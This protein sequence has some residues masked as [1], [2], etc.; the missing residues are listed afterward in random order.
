MKAIQVKQFGEPKVM[1]IAEVA[2]LE[3]AADQLLIEVKAIGVNPVDTY[4]R[5]GTYPIKPNLPYTPGHDAAGVVLKVGANVSKFKP[6]DRV[7]THRNVSGSY[8][9]QVLCTA[10]QAGR[11]PDNVDFPAGAALGV[12]YSTAF[13]GLMHRGRAKAGETVLIHG[14]SGAVGIAAIQ[15]AKQL[16]MM[17]I[18]TAGTPEG[19]DLIRQ[20]GVSTALNHHDSDYLQKIQEATQGQGVDLILEMLA[21]VNLANDLQL[22]ARNGRV[23][24]IGNRGSIEINPRDTMGK[25]TSIMGLALM[26]ATQEEIDEI[27]ALIYAGL[28]DGRFKPVIR[29]TLKLEDAPKAHELVMQPG[30]NGK[31]VML[32]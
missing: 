32:P 21:N 4:I 10:G 28:S 11:L 12:A 3:P 7:Y 15:Y 6:G 24:I 2:D 8:A 13:Y 18:G 25:N 9:E 17:I 30:G 19:M 5:S 1:E 31:I 29:T 23:V 26:N 14:A 27:Q 16:G 20:Q 22:L